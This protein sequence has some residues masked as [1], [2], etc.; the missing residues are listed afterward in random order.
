LGRRKV[1]FD[2]PAEKWM[3]DLHPGFVRDLLLSKPAR[4]RDL[5]DARAV[6]RLLAAPRRPFWFDMV[7][8]LASIEAWAST[9]LDGAAVSAA[10]MAAK[11]AYPRAG[12]V[13]TGPE[14]HRLSCDVGG[15]APWRV[16]HRRPADGRSR[17]AQGAIRS[18]AVASPVSRSDC[19][20]QRSERSHRAL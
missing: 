16:G 3:R 9:F 7:W 20:G 6:E 4:E 14:R 1:G 8:K 13:R 10:G 2:T 17:A 12:T 5:Y 19:C 18:V 15:L 11:P